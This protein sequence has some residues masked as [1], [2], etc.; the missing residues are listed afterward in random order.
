MRTARTTSS[1]RIHR[2]LALAGTAMLLGGAALAAAAPA[3]AAGAVLDPVQVERSCKT[4]GKSGS[5]EKAYY[6]SVRLRG[7]ATGSSTFTFDSL[8]VENN[9]ALT[10]ITPKQV[11]VPA[12]STTTVTIQVTGATNSANGPALLKATATQGGVTSQ[13]TGTITNFAPMQTTQCGVSYPSNV[14]QPWPVTN[15]QVVAVG[16]SPC[17]RAGRT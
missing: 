13:H 1:T 3:Q 9:P 11:S 2:T 6:S 4:P 10:Q 16:R 7:S 15:Q 17:P 5:P 8:T 14:N 12:H